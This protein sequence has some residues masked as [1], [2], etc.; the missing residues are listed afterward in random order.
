MSCGIGN[1]IAFSPTM[2]YCWICSRIRKTRGEE[3]RIDGFTPFDVWSIDHGSYPPH[4]VPM[5]TWER[6][7]LIAVMILNIFGPIIFVIWYINVNHIPLIREDINDPKV[8]EQGAIYFSVVGVI[9]LIFFLWIFGV[10]DSW[11]KKIKGLLQRND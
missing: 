7:G 4:E 8:I 5:H 10:L 11:W 9:F 3:Y 1:A 2:L 6:A